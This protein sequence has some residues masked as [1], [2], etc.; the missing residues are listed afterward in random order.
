MKDILLIDDDAEMLQSLARALSPLIAPLTLCGAGHVDAAMQALRFERPKVVVLDLC[1]DERVGVDSGFSLLDEILKQ[2]PY[3]RVVIL[4]GHGSLSHGVR[5]LTSGAASFVEKPVDPAHLAAL[6]IDAARQADVWK[7][8][9]RLRRQSADSSHSQLVG[10]SDKMQR[11]RERIHFAASTNQPVLILGETGTGKGLCARILHEASSKS[12]G[13]FVHYQPNFGGGDLVQSELFGHLKGAFTGAE[14]VRRGLALEAHGGTLFID[15]LDEIPPET[16]VKLLDLIQERRVRAL[17][18]DTYQ[19]VDCRFVAATNRLV[20][21]ALEEGKIRRDLYHR[22]AH[23]V[24]ELPPLRSRMEDI[25]SLCDQILG[26]LRTREALNVF[27]IEGKAL[28]VLQQQ[29]WPGNVRELQAVVTNAAY[30]A[31]YSG[32]SVIECEDVG[33][34][35]AVVE[36]E[37]TPECATGSFQEAV[38]AF[39][40]KLVREALSR[41]GGN[42]LKAAIELGLDRK[43][44]R[45][46]AQIEE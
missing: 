25:P 12:T 34:S 20:P 42:Q 5:A 7:E 38:L 23:C 28:E 1:L 11:L 27:D 36:R 9:E 37:A 44:L 40:S 32:R 6:V 43:T 2:S 3:A 30:Q 41:S 39:K 4:T 21:N 18:S 46:L 13:K 17:G 22:I 15:E 14:G 29:Q 35:D 8:Y 19:S 24:L 26:D 33:R 31:R 16:Q 10:M 45:R